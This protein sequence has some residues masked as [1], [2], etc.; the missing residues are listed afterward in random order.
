MY[1][2]HYSMGNLGLKFSNPKNYISKLS[3]TIISKHLLFI[4]R[5]I[6]I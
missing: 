6:I 3:V 4:D 5:I 2:D 1:V